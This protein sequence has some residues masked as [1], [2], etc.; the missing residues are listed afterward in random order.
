MFK[1]PKKVILS[2]IA[3]KAL[4]RTEVKS[5]IQMMKNFNAPG[6]DEITNE[7]INLIE[8]LKPDLIHTVL[9]CIWESKTVLMS[10][11]KQLSLWE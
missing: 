9:E 5:A 1:A 2:D 7:D 11:A 6:F 8:H 3:D 10:I 4:R